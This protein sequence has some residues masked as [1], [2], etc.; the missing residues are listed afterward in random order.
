[1]DRCENCGTPL[2][3]D[4]CHVCGQKAV[5]V[6]RP[7][8]GLAQDVIVE[9]LSIDGRLLRTI[10]GLFTN[11]GRVAK[12]YIEGHRVQYS[13]PFRIYLFFSL[14]FFAALFVVINDELVNENT[15]VATEID[16]KPAIAISFGEDEADPEET[17]IEEAK[18]A[19]K[20][21][22]DAG[23]EQ[24]AVEDPAMD[25]QQPPA[26]DRGPR[27]VFATEFAKGFADGAAGKADIQD[28]PGDNTAGAPKGEP[29]K[30]SDDTP[31]PGSETGDDADD[32]A[33]PD[34]EDVNYNGPAFL[35]P[36]AKRL[37]ANIR[38]LQEDNR[39]FLANVKDNLPRVLF[40][41]PFLYAVL[42]LI[43]YFYK[44]GIFV[45]DLLIVSLYMHAAL[46]FYLLASILFQISP[47][48]RVPI[49][50]HAE[51][52][53]QIWAVI[54]SYRVLKI[55]FGSGRWSYLL[56]GSIINFVYWT[57]ASLLIVTGMML[58][59]LG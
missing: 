23:A 5:E 27:G 32:E 54:Q 11:P 8:L 14:V 35:E 52:L 50:G 46:Y 34:W 43:F 42:L 51:I 49:L 15:Q 37:H 26:D 6:R 9:T 22:E 47:L 1:M 13:P 2:T 44:K 18:A 59:L 16:G 57:G 58:S 24:V 36:L 7:V 41:L 39:L 48:N 55:N 28:E 38:L 20:A 19:D 31:A 53:L 17:S 45:Y 56:K 33:I 30:S 12:R 21:V 10:I 25:T 40:A 4:F 3:G 29:E